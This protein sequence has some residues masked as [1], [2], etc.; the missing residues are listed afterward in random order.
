[1]KREERERERGMKQGEGRKGKES[2]EKGREKEERGIKGTEGRKGVFHAG[3]FSYFK[4]RLQQWR[5]HFG[6][7]SIS[8][9]PVNSPH[10]QLVTCDELT[11]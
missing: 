4:P 7:R 3:S 8:R 6:T 1:M 11:V 5:S 9:L 10:G 2:K